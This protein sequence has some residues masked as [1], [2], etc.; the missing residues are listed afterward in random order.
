MASSPSETSIANAALTLL[1]ERRINSL[2]E[3]SKTAKMLKER[4][5]EVRD[6]VLR[7]YPW[8]FATKRAALAADAVAPSWGFDRAFTL[9]ADCLRLL[10]LENPARYEYRIE[11]RKIITDL[12]TPLNIEY[13]AQITDPVQ[14]DV[15]FRQA[16]AAALAAD[17]AEA[18]TGTSTK[19]QELHAIRDAKMKASKTPDGQEHSPRRI[20]A[21]EWLDAREEIGFTRRVPTGEGT[22]L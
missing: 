5:D 15:M 3:S 14:M 6:E 12:G 11:G 1:G 18:M 8:N 20:E 16:F 19:V 4:F 10:E 13:T 2:D 17:V 21:S 9:P 22:P 7:A